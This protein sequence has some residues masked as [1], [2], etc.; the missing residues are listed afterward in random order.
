M[1]E[2]AKKFASDF[3]AATK[4]EAAVKE[5]TPW[6]LEEVK[7][8]AEGAGIEY[9]EIFTFQCMDECWAHQTQIFKEARA[10]HGDGSAGCTSMAIPGK[11]G[12]PSMIGQSM[13]L[14]T[15]Y[16]GFQTVLEIE[17]EDRPKQL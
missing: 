2:F 17:S 9:N 15:M 16:D 14:A 1:G 4:Y 6:L 3:V 10:R 5:H 12:R 7:G 11:G 13:D 8:I